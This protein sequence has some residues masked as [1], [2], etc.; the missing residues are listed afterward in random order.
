MSYF[1]T[2]PIFAVLLLLGCSAIPSLPEERELPVQDIMLAAVCEL[3]VAFIALKDNPQ[4][5]AFKADDWSLNITLTP[6]VDAQIYASFGHTGKS[7]TNPKDLSYITWTLGTSPGLRAG[8]EGH[9]DGGVTFALRSAQLLDPRHYPLRGCDRHERSAHALS[10]YL[11]I[12]EWL[13]RIVPD[14]VTG[15]TKFARLDKPSY[16]SQIIVKFDAGNAGVTF[17]VPNASTFTPAI[18]GLYKRDV[19]LSITMTP[20]PQRQRVE[21]VPE[22][23]IRK[24]R[25]RAAG[26]SEAAQLRLD[27]IQLERAIQNLRIPSQ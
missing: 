25:A 14:E 12:R 10:Q 18:A 19:T 26:V 23:V 15:L 24:D 3:R 20:E 7:T 4:Y 8:V 1:R 21:T 11:G 27:Q 5:A 16:T 2:L 17:F 6:K 13:E 22:G 9:R